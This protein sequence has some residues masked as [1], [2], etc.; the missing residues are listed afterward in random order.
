MKNDDPTGAVSGALVPPQRRRQQK[1]GLTAAGDNDN[2]GPRDYISGT[3]AS[4]CIDLPALVVDLSLNTPAA[5]ALNPG[6]K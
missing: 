5:P 1:P 6:Y 4:I 3:S 2:L